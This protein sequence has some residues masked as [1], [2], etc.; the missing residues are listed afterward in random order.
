MTVILEE[1]NVNVPVCVVSVKAR[2]IPAPV[3]SAP[4]INIVGKGM[5]VTLVAIAVT[6]LYA[7]PSMDAVIE[8]NVVGRFKSPSLLF[9]SHE[10]TDSPMTRIRQKFANFVI[11]PGILGSG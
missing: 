6:A 11:M 9:E 5:S 4:A 3:A 2:P 10:T 1:S 7:T 8:P